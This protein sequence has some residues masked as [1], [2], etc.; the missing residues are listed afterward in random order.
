L[1]TPDACAARVVDILDAQAKIMAAVV[2]AIMVMQS[3]CCVCALRIAQWSRVVEK[4]ERDQEALLAHAYG[5]N[6]QDIYV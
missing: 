3:I 2:L 1:D 5:R 4:G 6:S